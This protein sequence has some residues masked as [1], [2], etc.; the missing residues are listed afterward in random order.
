M[1]SV[2]GSPIQ[3]SALVRMSDEAWL[4]AMRKYSGA[5]RHKDLHKGGA[6]EL[7]SVLSKQTKENPQRFYALALR[8]PSD[9]DGSYARAFIDG[10]AESD[11]P[12]EWLFD[13]VERF[14]G[15]QGRDIKR[16]I[17]WALEKRADGGLSD[18]MLDLLERTARAPVGEDEIDQESSGQGPHSIYINSSRGASLRALMRA[19]H[20]RASNETKQKMWDLLEFASS[21]PSTPMRAGA[22][23]ELLYLLYEDRERAIALFERAMEGHPNLL[24][25]QPGPEFLYYGTYKHFSRMKPFV[26]AMM[27]EEKEE[28]R[29][30]GDFVGQ[31]SR[32]RGESRRRSR[33]GA[34]SRKWAGCAPPWGGTG[35]CTQPKRRTL[36]VLRAGV[37]PVT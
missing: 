7:S 35:L 16:T 9:V 11:G 12:D 36:G 5:T 20:G 13:M 32:I 15:Q 2:V 18:E 25:F 30:R 24:C 22:I 6:G 29:Q 28:C 23:E 37:E 34:R 26:Q 8:A 31:R 1:A 33:V 19:L 21:D 27:D 4:R 17:A 10:L 14:A 3:D